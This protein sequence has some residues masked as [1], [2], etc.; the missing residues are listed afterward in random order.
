VIQHNGKFSV[1]IASVNGAVVPLRNESALFHSFL[2][3]FETTGLGIRINADF[4]TD[5]SR[6]K[7]TIDDHSQE[8][9][10]AVATQISTEL[11]KSA[12][13]IPSVIGQALTP[14][15]A[16]QTFTQSARNAKYILAEKI[17]DN[18]SAHSDFQ[19]YKLIPNWAKPIEHLLREESSHGNRVPLLLNQDQENLFRAAGS[20]SLNA[21]EILRLVDQSRIQIGDATLIVAQFA[22]QY[23]VQNSADF[24]AVTQAEIWFSDD[25]R[26]RT[27]SQILDSKLKL[28]EEF[29][30]RLKQCG[31]Q[32]ETLRRLLGQ[33]GSGL[34]QIVPA[35]LPNSSEEALPAGWAALGSRQSQSKGASNSY[36]PEEQPMWRTAEL[37][38]LGEL[39]NLG[40]VANDVSRQFV[41]YDIH[42]MKD[43]R[44]YFVEVKKVSAL[45]DSFVLTSNEQA[46]ASQSG[47]KFVIALV[48]GGAGKSNLSFIQNPVAKLGFERQCQKW[49]WECASYQDS[50]S[51]E[52]Q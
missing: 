34:E 43:S 15:V 52:I 23:A 5:P 47:D 33:V 30:E 25:N 22:N 49:V 31:L 8:I 24:S 11:M 13:R 17:R 36:E 26:K 42:A 39:R 51:T 3:T 38:V 1:G 2:P 41:G 37:L 9:I 20:K 32:P 19:Q 10:E 29:L 28:S 40:Y 45:G 6:T 21:N 7:L 48:S 44:E 46:F 14:E 16:P 18:L 50:L 4:S 35:N 27:C 12:S